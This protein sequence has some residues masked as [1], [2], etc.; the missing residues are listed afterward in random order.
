MEP[1]ARNSD[2]LVAD[3]RKTFQQADKLLARDLRHQP[4]AREAA[5]SD[6]A[7]G[8]RAR[9]KRAARSARS[10]IRSPTETL[11]RINALAD[12]LARTS[13]SLD[14]LAT[15][16]KEQP[17]SLVFGRKAGT[18]GPGETGF[19]ARDKGKAK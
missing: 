15:D 10:P 13:R 4:R 3:A 8:R 17:Q 7:R 5:G 9:R 18:P 2:A 14:R 12:E 11:P 16:L 19:E 1:A 6:R